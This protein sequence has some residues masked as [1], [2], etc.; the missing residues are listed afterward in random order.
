MKKYTSTFCHTENQI[1][2][3]WNDTSGANMRQHPSGINRIS[4]SQQLNFT[5]KNNDTPDDQWQAT[6]S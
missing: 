2:E 1:S 5:G 3:W 4:I 6:S